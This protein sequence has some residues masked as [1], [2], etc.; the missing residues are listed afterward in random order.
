MLSFKDTFNL[1]SPFS[2][3]IVPVFEDVL[4][5]VIPKT[6]LPSTIIFPDTSILLMF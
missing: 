1:N 3:V 2:S 4:N 6:S 5:M